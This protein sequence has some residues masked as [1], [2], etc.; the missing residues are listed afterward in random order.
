MKTKDGGV[1]KAENAA[2]GD[3]RFTVKLPLADQQNKAG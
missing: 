3:C 1:V 2:D